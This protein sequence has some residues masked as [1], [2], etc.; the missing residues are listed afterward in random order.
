MATGMT[1]SSHRH[2]HTCIM[3]HMSLQPRIKHTILSHLVSF[4]Y[5]YHCLHYL[6]LYH[7]FVV[8][9]LPCRRSFDFHLHGTNLPHDYETYI[10]P[11]LESLK[12][13]GYPHQYQWWGKCS[14][15]RSHVP[16]WPP[17]HYFLLYQRLWRFQRRV[18]WCYHG[19]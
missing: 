18:E 6:L 7:Y 16:L 5:F 19:E 1:I 2:T 17:V 4:H 13:P 11:Q 8:F 12:L 10:T 14:N 15:V 3:T 9:L